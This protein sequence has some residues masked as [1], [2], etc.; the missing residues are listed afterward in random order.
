MPGKFRL[1]LIF[2]FILFELFSQEK[3]W[4]MT[5]IVNEEKIMSKKVL[6]GVSYM[7]DLAENEILKNNENIIFSNVKGEVETHSLK[8]IVNYIFSHGISAF[9]YVSVIEQDNTIDID[10]KLYTSIGNLLFEDKITS[11]NDFSHEKYISNEIEKKWINIINK[12][13]DEISKTPRKRTFKKKFIKR[14]F[15]FEHDFPIFSLGVTAL[16]VR[17]YFDERMFENI[18]N[19]IFSVFPIETRMTF[20]PLRYFEVGIFASFNF[21]NMVYAYY[22]NKVKQFKNFYPNFILFYGFFTG[23]SF[24]YDNN[25]YSLGLKVSNLFYNLSTTPSWAKTN[26]YYSY[27]LPQFSIYQRLDFKIFKIVYFS[28]S[29]DFYTLSLFNL[30]KN[31]YFYSSPFWYDFFGIQ[32]SFV[33]IS[34]II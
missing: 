3:K 9:Y 1:I 4:N 13:I 18:N 12:S 2:L 8:K 33:G 16:S 31:N 6:M 28:I 21:E 23:L 22:D 10:I 30:N 17:M 24:F 34:I 11:D 19:K 14:L 5:F 25:H 20:F 32:V 27:F 7:I 26:N 29:F 15:K